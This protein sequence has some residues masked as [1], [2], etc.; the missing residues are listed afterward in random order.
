MTH[1]CPD[2]PIILVGTKYDLRTDEEVIKELDEHSLKPISIKQG[3]E[4][5]KEIGA[6]KYIECSA[7]TQ[8]G[9]KEVFDEVVKVVLWPSSKHKQR[10]RAI[11]SLLGFVVAI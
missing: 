9:L 7:L 10:K 1:N 11:C 3:L 2:T 8:Y 5:Q 6:V 4:L